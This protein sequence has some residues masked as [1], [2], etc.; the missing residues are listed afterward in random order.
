ML[1]LTFLAFLSYTLSTFSGFGA[2]IITITLGSYFYP[3]KW[4][5]PVLMPV[6]LIS[7]LIIVTRHRQYVD[8]QILLKTVM[9]AMG[10]GLIVGIGIFNYVPGEALKRFL[11]IM[12]V[13]L[14]ARELFN[15]F[16]RQ[17][18]MVPLSSGKSIAYIL[19]AGVI[20]GIYA[21]GGPLLVYALNRLNLSKSEFRST[22]AAIWSLINIA[23]VTSYVLTGRVTSSSLQSSLYILPSLAFGMFLGE[24]M[25]SR[26]NERPFR[27][28]TFILLLISGLPI[29]FR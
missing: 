5:L 4:M 27:I 20:H 3:V 8:R 29:I 18:K 28:F 26:I 11:G 12:I 25:H 19:S 24:V 6:T 17:E 10:F 22:L 1:P 7:N 16:F 23:L 14:S 15:M 2:V 13:G 9:P 21:T